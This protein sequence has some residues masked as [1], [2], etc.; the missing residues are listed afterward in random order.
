MGGKIQTTLI[1]IIG[2]LI[3]DSENEITFD[4]D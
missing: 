2:F 3:I 1:D 4:S